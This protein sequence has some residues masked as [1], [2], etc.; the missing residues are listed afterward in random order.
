MTACG[1][2]GIDSMARWAIE[3]AMRQGEM[4]SL[5]WCDLSG[6]IARL[7]DSKT[8]EPRAVPLSLAARAV[9]GALPRTGG[10]ARIFPISVSALDYRFRLACGNA[11]IAGLRWH[12][13]RHEAVS[14][15][16]EKGLD[17]MEVASISGHRTLAMLKRYTHFRAAALA[18]KLG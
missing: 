8:N 3:T 6:P 12:D 15:L 5:R 9:L 7:R 14:R 10:N 16:F 4:L 11:A 17:A 18:A 2:V 1:A 13:L